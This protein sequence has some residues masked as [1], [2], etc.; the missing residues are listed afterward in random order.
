MANIDNLNFK[1]I[2]DDEQF[3]KKIAN[4][5]DRAKKFN[6]TMSTYLD[7]KKAT[8]DWSQKD[9]ESNQNAKR[10]KDGEAKAQEKINTEKAK[11]SNLQ[12][13]INS[14]IDAATKSYKVQSRILNEA[15]NMAL[16][17]LSVHGATKLISSLVRVT[18]EFELQK[19]TLGAMLGDLNQAEM[20]VTRIQ[21]LAVESP[22]QFKEL[23]TY[24]KQLSAFSVPAEELYDTTKMLADV[25]AGLGVGMD[26]LVLAYGQ[27]RSAAF[28]RG[29]EVRQFT[30][31][32]IP[33]LE[34][35][36]KQFEELEG[37]AVSTGEVFDRISQ[38]LVPFEMVA[39]AFKDMTSEGGKFYNMQEIQAE[40]LRGKISNLKDAYEVML[41]EI[42]EGQSKRLKG[43][44]D[45]LRKLMQNYEETGRTIV[46][47]VASYGLYKAALIAIDV[48]TK[49]FSETNYKLIASLARIGKWVASNP[50]AM[51]AASLAAMGGL[52]YKA[53]TDQDFFE[54][55]L[56]ITN[57]TTKEFNKNV[58]SEKNMLNYLLGRLSK[59]TAGTKEY[60]TIKSEILRNYSHYLDEVD[61][62]KL[63]IGDL[64]GMYEKLSDKILAA[65]K[66][67]SL[68]EGMQ[69]L[70]Q[71][72]AEG[73]NN[74][75]DRFDRT[76]EALGV[77]DETIKRAL[78]DFVRG[79][80]GLDELPEEAK[81]AVNKAK[82]SIK[83][84]ASTRG[85]MFGSGVTFAGFDFER[86]R[87]DL[88]AMRGNIE[89]QSK[90]LEKQ[91]DIIYGDIPQK[92]TE[93]EQK[94]ALAR[95]EAIA[96]IQKEIKALQI[97]KREFDDWA[98]LGVD[99]STIAS[100]LQNYFPNIQKAFG[101]NFITNLD[102]A[103]RLL[104]KIKEL[105][106]LAPE[107]AFDLMTTLGLDKSALEKQALK[108]QIKAYDETAKAVNK[109]YETVRK[110]AKEDFNLNGE[111]IVLDVSKIASDLNGKINEIE[112][113]ATKARELFSQID[114]NSEEEIAKVKEIF[115]KEFGPDAWEEF[116]NTYYTSG[117]YAI[118]QLAQKQKEY[119]KKLAQERVDDLAK[120]FVKESYFIG[121][122]EL[123]DLSDKNYFQIRQ[124][125]AKLQDL[126]DSEPLQVPVSLEEELN[127]NGIDVNS[128][129][130]VDLQEY[131]DRIEIDGTS[132][133]EANKEMLLLIQSIQKAGLST[134]KFGDTVKKV[135]KGDIENLTKEE[136]EALF[137][138]V[139]DYLGEMEKMLSS[140]SD[141]AEAIGNDELQGA[142]NGIQE[143]MSILGSIADRL[144]KGDWVGAIVSGVTSLV[145]VVFK[146]AT[147]QAELNSR[148]AETR[149]EMKL[150]AAQNAINEDVETVFGTNDYKK[151][152][153]A[154]D[155]AVKAH[156][157]AIKD[158]EKQNEDFVGGTKDN[159]GGMS[160]LAG[161]GGGAAL[162]AA[163]G[164]IVPV[165]G[166]AIGA[167]LG[168]L[169][170]TFVGSIGNAATGANDY[171]KSLQEMA[172]E[173]GA[174]LI[175]DTTGMF[176]V[177]TL[178]SIKE[179]YTDLDSSS[180][181]MLDK[182]ITNAQIYEDAI[183][184]MAAYM[185]DI[186]GQCADQMANSF[187]ESFKASGQAALE[188][189]D[190]MDDV[191]TS[192]AQS[193]IKAAI[194]ENVFDEEEAKEAAARLA[195]GDVA[196]A[197]GI[198]DEAMKSAEALTPSIQKLLESLQPY[199]EMGGEYG[200]T[201]GDGIKG[202]TED[203]ANLLAS[204][205][206]AI[207][208][209]VSISKG[210]WQSIASS[211]G[212]VATALS[213]FS[214]PTLME[215]QAQI[216]ANTA[217]SALATQEI[218]NTLGTLL[219]SEGGNTA[220][221][222]YS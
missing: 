152:L 120:K 21:G 75:F 197:M 182:L 138:L 208:A 191:A 212:H 2:I 139:E 47:L 96:A 55:S 123:S 45:W 108:E 17:Y 60:N 171:M 127:K 162:G 194:L 8:E 48:A 218:L 118:D 61:K 89:A 185:T 184:E 159:W 13:Q 209:D 146:A 20:I 25:S 130:D 221:R 219:T 38:R 12:S 175:D 168:A 95:E 90:D 179:T 111:G 213:G 210:I 14:K 82:A 201:L 112:L 126:L 19:T 23:T 53:A 137:S 43:A 125:R 202:I 88:A 52:L 41:K 176:N 109:Y 156:K 33:I 58:S 7:I 133:S 24:A 113:R 56:E 81:K 163:V 151:F 71:H 100:Y 199:F 183:T 143:A 114:I 129:I 192:I 167:V 80:I 46:T 148:I 72:F 135:I 10:A 69:K 166:T 30:E 149:E 132:I 142:I 66:Q 217:N 160:I 78:A 206:N 104:E 181:E 27:V 180:K 79:D 99:E 189:G 134:E 122:V 205:L 57:K 44:V 186:F 115:V 220:L 216:A 4:L 203:T 144:A 145:S 165:I 67:K 116:W 98:A 85:G 15:K 49:T 65:N 207:R 195:S 161:A 1:V 59:L 92:Q 188:Y 50:Y 110:W 204:Y 196:G 141:Y 84:A 6:T 117:V 173:I 32:G 157:E 164:S 16:G 29:Q 119:E 215:Y 169:V 3:N 36:A 140:I 37:Q 158:I 222:V 154:Y 178:K 39:K 54:K 124:I 22:F 136:A 147:A 51:L 77:Q 35:L 31:A 106:T 70:S 190:I 76:I 214:A 187:I 121:S 211:T 93:D 172:N 97:L 83:A 68:T 64:A 74:I 34:M 200:N 87:N 40:T 91:L 101:S 73:H 105:E 174:D 18:G 170:G 131:F 26:R 63:A 5:E 177:E 193:V 28:L 94:K 9:V 128:L 198:V 102:Y 62:E 11:S 153:N 155:L 42:G 86:L 150:L 103:T 107:E